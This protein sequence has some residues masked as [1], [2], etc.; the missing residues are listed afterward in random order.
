MKKAITFCLTLL[1]AMLIFVLVN[2]AFGA[3]NPGLNPR[4]LFEEGWVGY[5]SAKTLHEKEDIY[6]AIIKV[7]DPHKDWYTVDEVKRLFKENKW[8]KNDRVIMRK[9]MTR[10]LKYDAGLEDKMYIYFNFPP[11]DEN[12]QFVIWRYP[13]KADDMWMYAPTLKRNRRLAA[14]DQEDH[15]MGST[16]TYE[17]IRRLMG[18]VGQTAD[19]FIFLLAKEEAVISGRRCY[20]IEVRPDPAKKLNTGYG[21]R[22]F[23]QA[24]NSPAFVRVEYFDKYGRLLKIQNNLSISYAGLWRPRLVEMYEAA[25]ETTTVLYWT[26]RRVGLDEKNEKELPFGVFTPIY[27]E[28]HGR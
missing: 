5:R 23:Y 17:D 4:K 26:E 18:E 2:S 28:R 7:S 19:Q 14:A 11:R 27:M 24:K 22:K 12:T 16:F 10:Y 21:L 20:V 6:M 8:E 13:N 9:R 1:L 3:D 25:T 15:F